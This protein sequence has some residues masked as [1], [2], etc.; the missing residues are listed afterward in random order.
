MFDWKVTKKKTAFT[1]DAKKKGQ[2]ILVQKKKQGLRRVV[3]CLFL[4]KAGPKSGC[5]SYLITIMIKQ[6]SDV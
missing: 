6:T 5:V 2:L 4:S 1:S 3:E